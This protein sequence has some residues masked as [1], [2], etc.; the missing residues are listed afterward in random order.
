MLQRVDF[1][2]SIEILLNNGRVYVDKDLSLAD[3][4]RILLKAYESIQESEEVREE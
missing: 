3:V 1:A 4:K 2:G